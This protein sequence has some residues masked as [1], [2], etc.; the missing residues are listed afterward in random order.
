MLMLD[1]TFAGPLHPR[2]QGRRGSHRPWHLQGPRGQGGQ[3]RSSST[4]PRVL[5]DWLAPCRS[6]R[7]T[8]RSS[9]STSSASTVKRPTA[10][11]YPSRSTL[12]TSSSQSSSSTRTAKTCS[13]ERA[14]RLQL[15][16]RTRCRRLA[17]CDAALCECH[18][19]LSFCCSNSP[20]LTRAYLREASI[21]AG[22]AGQT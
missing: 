21:G 11:P 17:G 14:S 15:P 22:R 7:S 10:L 1:P 19:H 13:S 4:W 20:V 18:A 5:T 2:P 6:S 12:P 9:A 16:L 3:K 8:A